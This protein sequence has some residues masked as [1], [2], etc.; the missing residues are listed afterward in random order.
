MLG[1]E[2]IVR[3]KMAKKVI[4]PATGVRYTR[5]VPP[6][7][8]DGLIESV[9][10][11]SQRFDAMHLTCPHCQNPI[12]IVDDT[13]AEVVC[14]SCG[15]S[16]QIDPSRVKTG[17]L[18]SSQTP[19]RLGKFELFEQLGVGGFGTVYKARDTE[20]DRIVALKILRAGNLANK[21][22]VERFLREARS[23]A[24]LKH[25]NIV[26][27][28]DAGE[29]DGACYIVS[30]LITGA[31]L[32]DRLATK[33]LT[34]AAAAGLIVQVAEALEYAH[35]EGVI[36]RDLKPS[37]IMLDMQDQPHLMDFG[38]AKREAGEI[39]ITL[40]GQVLGTPAYMSPE[41]ARGDSHDVD[42]RSDIYS[43]GVILYELLTGA[44]PFLGNKRML[45]VQV[46]RD[47]P[48]APR[49][50]N[51][52]IPRDLETI[53]VKAM[54]KEP[55]RRYQTAADFA[56]DLQRYLN[57]EPVLARPPGMA[58]RVRKWVQRQP[59]LAAIIAI[60]FVVPLTIAALLG[61]HAADLTAKNVEIENKSR[62]V[63]AERNTAQTARDEEKKLRISLEEL[64]V[65]AERPV[66]HAMMG[67]SGRAWQM[68]RLRQVKESLDATRPEKTRGV[69]LRGWE[70]FHLFHE[71]RSEFVG[72]G[73]HGGPV[74]AAV[75]SPDGRQ[76]ASAGDDGT[77]H[78]WEASTGTRQ[79]SWKLPA[80][81]SLSLAFSPDGSRLAAGGSD[82]R[83]YILDVAANLP[84]HTLH[85]HV[86]AINS[87][88]YSADGKFL[89]TAGADNT[90]KIW[91]A[92][93][94]QEQATLVGHTGEV[95]RLWFHHE[96]QRLASLGDD[97]TL[98]FWDL[99]TGQEEREAVKKPIPSICAVSPDLDRLAIWSAREG[100]LVVLGI[101]DN[102]L[103]GQFPG[104]ANRVLDVNFSDS[105]MLLVVADADG[106]ATVLDWAQ[107]KLLTHYRGSPTSVAFSAA[108]DR[109]IAAC[110]DDRVRVW[111]VSSSKS[112][113]FV[114][115]DGGTRSVAF[116]PHEPIVATGDS[117]GS[118]RLWDSRAGKMIR[119]LGVHIA[120]RGPPPPPGTPKSK[121][122][123]AMSNRPV[124][125]VIHFVPGTGNVYGPD[126]LR[127][128][129]IFEGHTGEIVMLA[130]SPNGRT[131]ASAAG[132]REIR[133]WDVA[134]GK[135]KKVLRHPQRTSSLAFSP[136]GKRLVTGCWDDIVRVWNVEDG[137]EQ[138]TLRGHQDNVE[139]VIFHPSGKRVASAGADRFIHIWD[140]VTGKELAPLRGH[141][142]SIH[143]LAASANGKL[144]ASGSS[145]QA[146]RIWDFDTGELRFILLGHTERISSLAFHPTEDRLVS[147]SSHGADR[148]ARFWDLKLGRE[149][150]AL[151]APGG[152][153]HGLAFDP[154]GKQLAL[155]S[156]RE[157]D[158][159]EAAGRDR[160]GADPV[161]PDVRAA[162]PPAPS[163]AEMHTKVL[164]FQRLG[165]LP[166]IHDQKNDPLQPT[167]PGNEFLVMVVS[168]P[169]SSLYP[170]TA[171]HQA[172][173]EKSRQDPE[174]DLAGPLTSYALYDPQRFKLVL[175]GGNRPG[176]AIGPLP[177]ALGE[178]GGGFNTRITVEAS[179]ST[180]YP[181]DRALLA[182]AWELAPADF[183]GPFRVQLDSQD[184]IAVPNLKLEGY[185][186]NHSGPRRARGSQDSDV[187]VETRT[188]SIF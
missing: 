34:F 24:Q 178:S 121:A 186:G 144:L 57:N 153:I 74:S 136:D 18:L 135:E 120:E 182:I 47:E 177:S 116:H 126:T 119:T 29:H 127:E 67:R 180:L 150:I 171:Q 26:S 9:P 43:L 30:E 45:I 102:K 90:I 82:S 69:D 71:T 91:N 50:L 107:E 8:A 68:G 32:A 108:G 134:T 75:F 185:S 80:A 49:R 152:R 52:K 37:N 117:M 54:S 162:E 53:T 142:D 175:P 132:D 1:E 133:L 170:T 20:L 97:R 138:L 25:P 169:H 155:T 106:D 31:T 72:Y 163:P 113:A 124:K 173:Q 166:K 60:G 56:A 35:R 140:T 58:Y 38:L 161:P 122:L 93:S 184:A 98:R 88:A 3:D 55:A 6:L 16:I 78:L 51:D 87:L 7:S 137:T 65:E 100:K 105:G 130:F 17:P 42:E 103:L 165:K 139:A 188:Y 114:G 73:G 62:E 48:R 61:W 128:A 112:K 2:L 187:L 22:N 159:W 96:K 76:A 176:F 86:L 115:H 118:I 66:Y 70:W 145:D 131:L 158:L 77:I 164:G 28:H 10:S 179:T 109:I 157:I 12:E 156:G 172:L 85:G 27:V 14:G 146:I 101:A 36:H 95:R 40:D 141:V 110:E 4:W 154:T 5:A 83:V 39:T 147:A 111:P 92:D 174:E 125:S 79:R 59:Y 81:G 148:N 41:Q 64:K 89:A 21:E 104:Y 123:A 13:D 33:R 19:R 149:I 63:A 84:L 168:L 160:T 99:A 167:K 44:L 46:L 143:A 181:K 15:S 94:G 23:A 129:H 151:P 11:V 183:A